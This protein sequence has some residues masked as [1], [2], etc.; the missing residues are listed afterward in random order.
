[1]E[2]HAHPIHVILAADQ[3]RRIRMYISQLKSSLELTVL[4]YTVP[5]KDSEMPAWD[6]LVLPGGSPVKINR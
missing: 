4:M 5:C 6:L 3:P 1:M 2:Q